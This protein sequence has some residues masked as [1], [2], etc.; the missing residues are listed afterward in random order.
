[1]IA[2][3]KTDVAIEYARKYSQS[4]PGAKILWVN[5]RTAHEFERSYTLI[6]RDIGAWRGNSNVLKAVRIHLNQA[7][8]GQW[9]MVVDG[10]DDRVLLASRESPAEP[11]RHSSMLD[12]LPL[13]SLNG[14]VLVTSRSSTLASNISSYVVDLPTLSDSDAA[15]VLCGPVSR[16]PG[17][18]TLHRGEDAVQLGHMLDWSP[19]AV[20]LAAAYLYGHARFFAIVSIKDYIGIVSR[21]MSGTPSMVRAH[22]DPRG[23]RETPAERA[24]RVSYECIRGRN[25]EAARLLEIA[26]AFDLQRVELLIL[27]SGKDSRPQPISQQVLLLASFG[28]VKQSGDGKAV[29]VPR[30]IQLLVQQYLSRTSNTAWAE[31]QERAMVLVERAYPDPDDEE[32]E[33]CEMLSVFARSVLGQTPQNLEWKQSKARL[34]H[35]MACYQEQVGRRETAM[36]YRQECLRLP[37]EVNDAQAYGGT[38]RMLEGMRGVEVS[39]H[40]AANTHEYH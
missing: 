13:K 38:G 7:V 39:A 37:G 8:N 34:L 1:M 40:V 19:V 32:Y 15:A 2:I 18:P 36:S 11:D 27:S 28:L 31:L 35:K 30:Q 10:L 22:E 4:F 5:A 3:R 16:D 25:P 23:A 29:S 9:L 14:R 24:F 26:S 33:T 20:S 17:K 21:G 6:A 12:F